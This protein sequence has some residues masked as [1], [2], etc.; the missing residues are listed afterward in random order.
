ML[1]D[2]QLEFLRTNHPAAM[3]S[4]RADGSPHTVRI[5]FG[6]IDGKLWSSAREDRLRTRF[7]RRD[8]RV[9]LFVWEPERGY[10]TV[11]ADVVILDGPDIPELSLGLFR[12]IRGV[13]P[14]EPIRW[15][16]GVMLDED[17][18]LQTMID[19]Q[20]IIY[21]FVPRRVYGEFYT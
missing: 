3:T 11:E 8:P 1:T 18:F 7:L 4:L 21:E 16:G 14:G 19:E 17:T 10:L 5:N 15:L 2:D 12:Q 9:S 6:V 20:R 13:G